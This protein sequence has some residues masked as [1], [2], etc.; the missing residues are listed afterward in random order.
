MPVVR[1]DVEDAEAEEEEKR[2]KKDYVV[3]RFMGGGTSRQVLCSLL[4]HTH[5]HTHTLVPKQEI[6][7]V[8]GRGPP[9]KDLI[10]PRQEACQ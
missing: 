10:V 3:S 2:R 6:S 4:P 7:L 9:K 8:F 1:M 5:A